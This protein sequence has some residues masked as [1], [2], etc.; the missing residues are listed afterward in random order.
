MQEV[1]KII[2]QVLQENTA[3]KISKKTGLAISSMQFFKN[4]DRKIENMT[5]KTA[6]KL[7]KYY[8]DTQKE[9]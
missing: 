5:L 4:G 1:Y 2:N 8:I 7:Y 3:Y 6:E 9:S